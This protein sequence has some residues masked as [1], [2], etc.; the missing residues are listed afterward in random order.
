MFTLKNIGTSG[1]ALRDGRDGK[2]NV[3]FPP[4]PYPNIPTS[5]LTTAGYIVPGVTV[6]GDY[7]Y[8]L[9]A[10]V[11]NVSNV[12]VGIVGD[13]WLHVTHIQGVDQD[14]S[15]D[16][17]TAIKHKGVD[18]SIELKEI[19]DE[20]V[21]DPVIHPIML[22]GSN[23]DDV[24]SIQASVFVAKDGFVYLDV[25]TKGN[26]VNLPKKVRIDNVEYIKA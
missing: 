21:L 12:L 11:Y 20:P 5:L 24:N 9:D 17:F 22:I 6:K 23:G 3:I 16:G 4:K 18:Q 19:T 14:Y 2:S 25:I 26:L 13:Q 10:P 7:I 8:T 15:V 1:I